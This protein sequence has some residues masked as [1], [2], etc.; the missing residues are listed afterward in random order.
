MI[1]ANIL[2]DKAEIIIK[3]NRLNEAEEIY[4]EIKK[5]YSQL[6]FSEKKQVIIDL[7]IG[8]L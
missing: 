3:L 5:I 1:R 2:K 6:N 7:D 4:R 8:K